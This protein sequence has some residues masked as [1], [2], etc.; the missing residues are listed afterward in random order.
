MLISTGAG[1]ITLFLWSIFLGLPL[2]L[3]PLQLLWLNLVTNGVQDV[4]LAFEPAEGNELK[5]PPRNPNEPIFDRLMVE[6]VIISAAYLGTMAFAVFYTILQSG[7][8]EEY[9][10]N[11]TLLLMVLF[12]NI[13]ALNSR[14]ETRSLLRIP[15][16]SNPLLLAGIV[17]AQSIHIGAM[18]VPGLSDILQIEPVPFMLWLKL[19]GIAATLFVIDEGHKLWLSRKHAH[20]AT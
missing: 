13:H 9:A 12:E 2:P 16:F 4:A 7:V 14:S 20:T 5:R 10:R 19:L 1:E 17:I 8:T 18:Y 15:V 6:R 3:F 11:V